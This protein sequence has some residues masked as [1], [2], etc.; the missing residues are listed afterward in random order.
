MRSQLVAKYL[1]NYVAIHN[2]KVVD[3]DPDVRTLHLRIRRRYGR[4]P[5]L[6]R[7]VTK[8]MEQPEMV[9]RSPKLER[10]R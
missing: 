2:G 6:L 8:D 10:I 5:I 4:A 7:Q 9:F 1:G 3:H